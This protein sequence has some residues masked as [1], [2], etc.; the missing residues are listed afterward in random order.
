MERV[1]FTSAVTAPNLSNVT[2]VPADQEAP[3]ADAARRGVPRKR[4]IP[5]S[6]AELPNAIVPTAGRSSRRTPNVTQV[7]L[8]PRAVRRS[9]TG[10]DSVPAVVV[11]VSERSLPDGV[12]TPVASMTRPS[13]PSFDC[14]VRAPNG[15]GPQLWWGEA[16]SQG[17]GR[18]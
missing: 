15:S 3:S 18:D 9:E 17:S 8:S 12:A 4:A 11:T 5:E 6:L 14:S 7:D 10:T 13:T 2:S 16:L 1:G